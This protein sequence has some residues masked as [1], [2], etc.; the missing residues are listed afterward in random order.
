MIAWFAILGLALATFAL[1][2]L[3]MK[4]PQ[5]SWALFGAVLSLGLAGYA[6]QGLPDQAS[7]P[8]QAAAD[9]QQSGEA[10]VEARMQLFDNTQ[11]KPGYLITSDAFA[12]Q[13]KFGDAATLLRKGLNDNPN[14]LEGWL[15]LAMSLTGHADGVVTPPA[16]YA[17]GR[18]R[19]IDPVNPGA[20]F[21][22][23]ISYLQV[24]EIRNARGVWGELLSRSPEDAPWRPELEQRVAALDKMI[25]NAPML[26]Q[27]RQ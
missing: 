1:A 21:F 14:H 17:Y 19:A 10:M 20:D 2:A 9:T 11:A 26:Q 5:Q 13:G 12:R 6:W 24:G 7:S 3:G 15:A 8:K 23:G 16:L 27:Q 25:A 22:L 4:L 18:A